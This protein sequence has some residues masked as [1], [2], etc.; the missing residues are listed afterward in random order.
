MTVSF[1]ISKFNHAFIH[2]YY[3]FYNDSFYEFIAMFSRKNDT[4]HN[5]N[6][7]GFIFICRSFL[8]D[9]LIVIKIIVHSIN[10]LLQWKARLPSKETDEKFI[11]FSI[12]FEYD[13]DVF[14]LNES[15]QKISSIFHPVCNKGKGGQINCLVSVLYKSCFQNNFS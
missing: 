12:S 4:T 6:Y 5:I 14:V 10:F 7:N 9:Q 8:L 15:F 11:F 1:H 2:F 13:S 3:M